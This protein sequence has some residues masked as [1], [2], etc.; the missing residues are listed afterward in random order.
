MGA[1]G[2]YIEREGVPTAQVSLIREQT[3]A[4]KPPRALWV[5]FM[6]GR[7]FG[8]PNDAA[9]QRRVLAALLGLFERADGPVLE[10]YPEDAPGEAADAESE[11]LDAPAV[12]VAPGFTQSVS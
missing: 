3:A 10:D 8:A 4:I 6:L 12:A 7:P 5:P 1:L 9:F 2:H 11:A